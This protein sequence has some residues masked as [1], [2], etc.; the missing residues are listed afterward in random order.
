MVETQWPEPVTET[1]LKAWGEFIAHFQNDPLGFVCTVF[2]WNVP[3]SPLESEEGPDAWQAV[4]L[5]ELGQQL[6]AGVQFIRIAV[7]SG[8]G[9]GK[10]T[11]M[12]WLTIWFQTCYPRNKARVTAG[13]M[14]Q[15]KSGTWREVAKWHEFAANRW[16][17]EWTQTKYICKWKPNTWYAEA[18]AWSEHNSQ[19]F[20]GV[21]EDMVM[22]EFDE[23]STIA[24][25]IW[26][27]S[28]GAFTTRGILLAFGN[29]TQPD[30]RF[31]E[32]FGSKAHRWTT[33]H[34]DSR[35]SRKANKELLQQWIDDWGIDSDYVRVRVLGLF[36][37]HGS[38]SFIASGLISNAIARRLNFD[39]LSIP[40]AIPLLMGVD[41][42]RQGEDQSVVIFRKGRYLLPQT[43]RYR[44]PDVM[45]LASHVAALIRDNR[46]DVVFVD[47]SGGYGA[48]LIDRLRQL[49]HQC[50]EVQFGAKADLPKKY[51]N[52]RAEIWSRMR[53]WI[54]DE[55][56]LP[57]DPELRTALECPGYGYDRKT[58]R[59][60]LESKDEIRARGG[61]SPDDADAIAVTFTVA[62]PVKMMDEEISL[63]PDVV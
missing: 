13:T 31:A 37:I 60:K 21:H 62:V 44:I 18:M 4:I 39:P 57:D 3:G 54:R 51:A 41:V 42:A 56:V 11:L 53:D 35:D 33:L 32:C 5:D 10:S 12:A 61:Q 52:K 23:A 9:S 25:V 55:A 16:Q 24:D 1:D 40:R 17:F 46:P 36:P 58:E 2:P 47:G 45:V 8:H 15:L 48:G 59:L 26:D 6:R 7:A 49:G 63:E 20:A 22:F 29:P 43:K 50:V 28:E 30:G 34:V 19:A 14:P 38:L 27:V